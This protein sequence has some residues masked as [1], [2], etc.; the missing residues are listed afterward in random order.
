MADKHIGEGPYLVVCTNHD[1]SR[2]IY[3][4]RTKDSQNRDYKF[5]KKHRNFRSVIKS[6]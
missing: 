6:T 3:H 5:A 4:H 2:E 1:G